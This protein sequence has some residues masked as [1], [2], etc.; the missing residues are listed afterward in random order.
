MLFPAAFRRLL[1]SVERQIGK[2]GLA[3]LTGK[4]TLMVIQMGETPTLGPF[5]PGGRRLEHLRTEES[6]IRGRVAEVEDAQD[7]K[8]CV[9]QST[10]GFESRLGHW[11]V[12]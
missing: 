12:R 8:S 9:E 11:L 4:C 3:F 6:Q 5:L 1:P 10:C 2:P 7:L